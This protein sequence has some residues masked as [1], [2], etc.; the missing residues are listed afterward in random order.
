[1][2]EKAKTKVGFRKILKKLW[3]SFL[4]FNNYAFTIST[5]F[6]NIVII[7]NIMW[8]GEELHAAE[9]AFL[10]GS[11]M[12]SMALSG[13]LFGYL[14][15][16]YSRTKLMVISQLI[17]GMGLFLNG[18]VPSGLGLTTFSYFLISNLLRSFASGGFQPL[19]NSYAYDSTEESERSQFFGL[20]QALFQVFQILGMLFSAILFELSL[21]REYFWILGTIA[22]LFG[23]LIL[24]K[25][26]EPKRA[27]THSILKDVLKDDNIKYEYKLTR[28]TI[29]ST[30]LA[31]TN[32][33]AFIEGIFTTILIAVPDFLLIAYIQSGPY[34]ISPLVTSI[35]LIL[36]G[37]PGALF[38]SL[39]FAKISDKL[40]QRNIKNRVYMI[41]FSCAIIFGLF[42][43]YFFLPLPYLTHAEGLNIAIVFA[44]PVTWGAGLIIFFARGVLG[45]W[46]I[47]QPPILQAINLPEAQAKITS[48]N[49]FLELIG[50]GTGTILAGS[51]LILFNGNF[52]LTATITMSLGII[53][54]LMWLVSTLWINKDVERISLI[55]KERGK[56]MNNQQEK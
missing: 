28:E 4:I 51:L 23:I 40:G 55:L 53:G 47:N 48:L 9:L 43:A 39:A 24:L 2:T 16:K 50:S 1:M 56:E 21:W 26:R 42:T 49:Q 22:F 32:I 15:D 25:A 31:P 36:F 8:P 5:L 54:G 37:L 7:S 20:L 19:I 3:Q 10:S 34:N 38:G 6:I 18:F 45:L 44:F 27:G 14:A 13:I 41:T 11:A 52:Q 17:F 35:L 29:R 33:I 46:N 30:I 12:Y